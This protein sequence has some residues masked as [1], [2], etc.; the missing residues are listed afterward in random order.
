MGSQGLL[1][2][3]LG[4][5]CLLDQVEVLTRQLEMRVRS[6]LCE[7]VVLYPCEQDRP[8]FTCPM[9]LI[10]NTPC[11]VA[12]LS[13][14]TTITE[15]HSMSG[16]AFLC[17]HWILSRSYKGLFISMCILQMDVGRQVGGG[18]WEASPPCSRNVGQGGSRALF[19]AP[20]LHGK[21]C[22]WQAVGCSPVHSRS[23]FMSA[24]FLF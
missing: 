9:T 1:S 6:S 12:S 2:G 13:L 23:S 4:L 16:A 15:N 14:K 19:P 18:T 5:G 20:Q 24:W 21:W 10:L 3:T 17:S 11:P 22:V 8:C 7:R